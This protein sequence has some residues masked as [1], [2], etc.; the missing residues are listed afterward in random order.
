MIACCLCITSKGRSPWLFC[1]RRTAG[2]DRTRSRGMFFC[3]KQAQSESTHLSERL[4][5]LWKGVIYLLSVSLTRE[6]IISLNLEEDIR[7]F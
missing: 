7:E 6:P 5:S 1:V 4:R 3:G 2:Q